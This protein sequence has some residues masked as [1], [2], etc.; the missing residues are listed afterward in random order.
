MSKLLKIIV[1][2]IVL[3]FLASFLLYRM[4]TGRASSRPA[5]SHTA[6]EEHEVMMIHGNLDHIDSHSK[7]LSLKDNAQTLEFVI[8]NTTMFVKDGQVVEPAEITSGREVAIRYTR[9]GNIN[10]AH[11]VFYAHAE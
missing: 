2:I 1:L 3:F 11:Y 5:G 10:T 4:H 9:S 7:T 8:D 6:A